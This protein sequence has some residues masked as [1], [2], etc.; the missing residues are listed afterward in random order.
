MFLIIYARVIDNKKNGLELEGP[1]YGPECPTMDA[2]HEECKNLATPSKD[3]LLF[4][5]LDLEEIDYQSAKKIATTQFDKTFEQ[6]MIAQSFCDAPRR[7][8][9]K[10]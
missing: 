4:K 3:N 1:F 7:K 2:A 6:M 5:I 10:R 8:K 9:I